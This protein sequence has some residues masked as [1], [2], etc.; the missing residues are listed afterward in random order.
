LAQ[1]LPAPTKPGRAIDEDGADKDVKK[2]RGHNGKFTIG[3]PTTNL[4]EP[5]DAD[6]Y[7]DY[8]AAL[9]RQWKPLVVNLRKTMG[10]A[11]S[12]IAPCC[13]EGMPAP[14][15]PKANRS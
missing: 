8:A 5:I 10:L 12:Y 14:I 1:D 9:N 4:T 6:G 2:P 3:R 11:L 13:W 7:I 15:Q